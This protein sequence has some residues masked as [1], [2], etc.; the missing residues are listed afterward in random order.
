VALRAL[1][2]IL[3]VGLVAALMLFGVGIAAGL[4]VGQ[5]L[6]MVL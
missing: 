3:V 1:A 4:G 5:L 2:V 6:G